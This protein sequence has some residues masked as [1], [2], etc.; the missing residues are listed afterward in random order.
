M[1]PL[2]SPVQQFVGSTGYVTTGFA[3][4]SPCVTCPFGNPTA[5]DHVKRLDSQA[6]NSV[7]QMYILFLFFC[8][9]GSVGW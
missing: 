6:C 9:T 5:A 4:H 3:V 7:T 1:I 8:F 2:L